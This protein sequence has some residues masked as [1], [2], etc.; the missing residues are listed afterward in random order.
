MEEKGGDGLPIRIF[1]DQGHNPSGANAGAEGYGL[2]EQDVNY[3]VGTR[4]AQLLGGDPRF[5]VRVS[6]STPTQAL[7]NS[8]AASLQARVNLANTWPADYFVSVH[9]NA[10]RNPDINGSEVYVYREGTQPTGWPSTCCKAC[11]NR[12]V[13]GTTGCGST[14][15]CTC[16]ARRTCP[17]SWWSWLTSPTWGTPGSS[18]R[19]RSP[20]PRGSTRGF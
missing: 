13:P 11:V 4:L 9:C 20:S 6:R 5:E 17:P 18:R 19:T 15:R 7:G 14:P 12:R 8:N 2:R 3:Q 16:C 10:N 1:V